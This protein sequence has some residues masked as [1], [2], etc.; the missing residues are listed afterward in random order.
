[1]TAEGF[2]RQTLAT[3]ATDAEKQGWLSTDWQERAFRHVVGMVESRLPLAGLTVHDA[4]CGFGDIVP[5]LTRRDIGRYVGTDL[6]P[7]M[8]A[9]ARERRP[10]FD[11]RE[12]DLRRDDPPKA[13]VTLCMGA[14]AYQNADDIE[15]ILQRLWDASSRAFG[16][17]AW[18][19][20]PAK[21]DPTGEYRR[22]EKRVR[23]FLRRAAPSSNRI[24]HTV[25]YGVPYEAAFVVLR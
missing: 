17:I 10:G 21:M 18:W 1:M 24:E 13:D 12:L 14:L 22:A 6:L 9:G 15:S 4:G 16:F 20:L 3:G 2:Y 7:G 25:E 19:G 5:T 8:V 11:F 23:E